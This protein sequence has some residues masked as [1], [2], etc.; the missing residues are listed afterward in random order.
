M[1]T[2]GIAL[3]V[4]GT[5]LAIGAL[6]MSTSVATET[7]TGLYGGTR[8]SEVYNLGLLQRQMMLFAAGLAVA[9]AGV[10]LTAAGSVIDAIGSHVPARLDRTEFA[11]GTSIAEEPGPTAERPLSP[12]ELAERDRGLNRA[13]F[14]VAGGMVA[15]VGIVFLIVLLAT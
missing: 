6:F 4:L 12:E 5:L 8:F 14:M 7:P 13:T 1:K 11:E 2:G 15:V 3:L 10:V 9:V